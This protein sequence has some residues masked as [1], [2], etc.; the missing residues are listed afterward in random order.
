MIR[1]FFILLLM[2]VN[3][4]C[5]SQNKLIFDNTTDKLSNNYYISSDNQ[6]HTFIKVEGDS[7]FADFI[8]WNKFP[9]RLISDTLYYKSSTLGY[10]GSYTFIRSINRKS[11]ICSKQNEVRFLGDII[12]YI[13]NDEAGYNNQ[14]KEKNY[15]LWYELSR[16]YLEKTGENA[17]TRFFEVSKQRNISIKLKNYS[18]DDFVKEVEICKKL[19]FN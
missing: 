1:S 8:L 5:L 6:V 16:E 19:L 10:Q 2:I 15:A 3:F 18:F 9:R 12:Q 4:S 11:Y 7:V 17:L 14:I 13:T